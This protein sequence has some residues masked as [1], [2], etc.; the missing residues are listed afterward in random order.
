ML[1]IQE[2]ALCCGDKV[3]VRETTAHAHNA[4]QGVAA[5]LA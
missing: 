4:H 5:W 2:S 3:F 1:T